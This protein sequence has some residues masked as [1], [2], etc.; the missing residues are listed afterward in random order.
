MSESVTSEQMQ[1]LFSRMLKI[2]SDYPVLLGN[3]T[4]GE[5]IYFYSTVICPDEPRRTE[6][7]FAKFG[8][9][10]VDKKSSFCF[11]GSWFD[12]KKYEKPLTDT[13]QIISEFNKIKDGKY[14]KSYDFL[15]YKFLETLANNF[16]NSLQKNLGHVLSEIERQ[17]IRQKIDL[18]N[19][20]SNSS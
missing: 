13:S 15:T 12:G 14:F 3:G 17:K 2:V 7:E 11:Y 9:E 8:I 16:G 5:P 20:T 6:I 4:L 19:I 1:E 18:E 10:I